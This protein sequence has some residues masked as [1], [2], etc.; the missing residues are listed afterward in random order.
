[1][2]E[3]NPIVGRSFLVL[4]QVPPFAQES[5]EGVPIDNLKQQRKKGNNKPIPQQLGGGR[6]YLKMAGIKVW[7]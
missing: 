5:E 2:K 1:M 7:Q 4:F 3:K 6:R